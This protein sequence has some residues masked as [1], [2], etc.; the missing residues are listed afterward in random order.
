[1]QR[2]CNSNGIGLR[3]HSK[4]L[5]LAR[6]WIKNDSHAHIWPY[7]FWPLLSHFGPIEL[8]FLWELRRLFFI[9]WCCEFKKLSFIFEVLGFF[10]RKVGVATT[11]LMVWGF[12]T[13]QKSWPTESIGFTTI[14]K[15]CF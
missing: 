13:R 7:F 9:D 4:Y 3:F 10:D 2:T 6:S 15:S 12:Q 11:P 14:S 1:M 8:T 5:Y